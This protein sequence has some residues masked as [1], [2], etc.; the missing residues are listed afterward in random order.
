[1][2]IHMI[3]F[4]TFLIFTCII[5]YKHL[6]T[7][8]FFLLLLD[9]Q[10]MFI[11]LSLNYHSLHILVFQD[12]E[13]SSPCAWMFIR[14]I[15]TSIFLYCI[16]HLLHIIIFKNNKKIF[17]FVVF[18]YF[19]IRLISSCIHSSKNL[20]I[21]RVYKLVIIY[22]SLIIIALDQKLQLQDYK[23]YDVLI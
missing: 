9:A 5:N 14:L 23:S 22:L 15:V 19:I 6:F 4:M 17:T 1:M 18:S 21:P 13:D 11:V 2:N 3:C 20:W 7:Y 12:Y 16:I 8:T 10:E